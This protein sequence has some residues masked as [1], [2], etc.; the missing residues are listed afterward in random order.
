MRK[1]LVLS[2]IVF[3]GLAAPAAAWDASPDAYDY[4]P[5]CKAPVPPATIDANS[6]EAVTAFIAAS[7]SYQQCLG[8]ALG[9]QQD[10]AFFAKT[11][12]PTVVVKQIEGRA[13]DNQRQKEAVGRAY[14]AA[15]GGGT[16]TP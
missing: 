4:A 7:D 16:G 5:A 9:A 1:T 3:I 2:A 12:V 13:R 10:T 14:N 6:H 11:N 8:R 15:V